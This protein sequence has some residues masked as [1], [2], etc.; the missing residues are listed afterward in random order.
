MTALLR[1]EWIKNTSTKLVWWMGV[2]ALLFGLL[3]L[4][5][6]L[7]IG[8]AVDDSVFTDQTFIDALFT[9][10]TSAGLFAL[11]LG[12]VAMT[13]EYR[14]ATI[15]PTYL[16]TP[17]RE[18]VLAAKAVVLAAIAGIIG[19][20]VYLLSSAIVFVLLAS[21]DHAPVSASVVASNALWAIVGFA[22]FA[23]I[24]VTFGALL[25]GQATAIVVAVVWLLVAEGIVSVLKPEVGK[26]LPG[27]AL[28]ALS[29]NDLSFANA[30]Q[31]VAYLPTIAALV[32]LVAYALV[33]GIA[34]SLT[35]LRRDVT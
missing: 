9:S 7:G 5:V 24:G 26:W 2:A 20:A 16:A 4:A 29:L 18:H 33:F 17:K 13:A 27:Q 12:I 21:K 32:V 11:V 10:T 23:A 30:N 15:A 3:N 14:H 31:D 1:S 25:R 28:K 22:L 6:P 35:T 19:L 8:I 34:A